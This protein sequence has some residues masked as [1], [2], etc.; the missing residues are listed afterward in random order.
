VRSSNSNKSFLD[1]IMYA[2][3]RSDARNDAINYKSWPQK[4]QVTIIKLC[5]MRETIAV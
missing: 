2:V 3:E 4:Y 5:G 1:A